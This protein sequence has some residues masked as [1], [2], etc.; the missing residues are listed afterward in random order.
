MNNGMTF[1][2]V[3]IGSDVYSSLFINIFGAVL[4]AGIILI[5][6]NEEIKKRKTESK[7]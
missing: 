7:Q 1:T 4:C 5:A 3:K 6:I 2:E